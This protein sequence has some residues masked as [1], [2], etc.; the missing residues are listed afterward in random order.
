MIEAIV[1]RLGR[2]DTC[3]VSDALDRIGLQGVALGLRPI[4]PTRRIAG[5]AVTVKLKTK[6]SETPGHHLGTR[7]IEAASPG[8]VIVVD[9]GGR[10]EVAG[11]GGILST[12]AKAKGIRGIVIDGACRDIDQSSELG[13]AVFARAAVPVTARGRVVEDFFN[14]PIVVCGVTVTP[15]D[16]VIA[17]G[18]GVVFIPAAHAK[19]VIAAAEEL[20]E[21]ESQMVKAITSGTSVSDV[22]GISYESLLNKESTQ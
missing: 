13:L 8:D 7:A 4:T 1:E 17:D 22:M 3:V 12:A 10:V 14:Q 11:W 16:L 5:R 6:E 19:E 2:L 21:L 15:G 9:H 18:S 20:A